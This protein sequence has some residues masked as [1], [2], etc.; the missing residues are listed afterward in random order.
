MHFSEQPETGPLLGRIPPAPPA[1]PP[2]TGET[3]WSD[4]LDSNA[5]LRILGLGKLIAISLAA[6]LGATWFAGIAAVLLTFGAG[7]V[8]ILFVPG[9]NR[10]AGRSLVAL[11]T[12]FVAAILSTMLLTKH[13]FFAAI[14]LALMISLAT[15]PAVMTLVVYQWARTIHRR[16]SA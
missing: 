6:L 8:V 15:A 10:I 14:F 2:T 4:P 11:G 16:A 3:G 13:R 9:S 5:P 1:A 7:A 12:T